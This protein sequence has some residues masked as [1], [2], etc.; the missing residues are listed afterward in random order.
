MA[1]PDAL[2]KVRGLVISPTADH[3]RTCPGKLGESM[4]GALAFSMARRALTQEASTFVA[5]L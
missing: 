2:G 1:D 5:G 3:K 4:P